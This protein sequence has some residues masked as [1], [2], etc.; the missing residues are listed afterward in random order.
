MRGW[1]SSQEGARS[2]PVVSRSGAAPGRSRS[3]TN[4][5]DVSR[6][7]TNTA[8]RP[9]P[10]TVSERG[11]GVWAITSSRQWGG[12]GTSLRSGTGIPARSSLPIQMRSS[13]S[14]SGTRRSLLDPGERLRHQ[15]ADR[16]QVVAA[17]LDE[18]GWE[19]HI[20]PGIRP[21][22][23]WPSAV[24]F[25][26]LSGSPAAA[27][28]PRATTRACCSDGQPAGS[29]MASS[30][31]SGGAFAGLPPTRAG[32]RRAVAGRAAGVRRDGWRER[33]ADTRVLAVVLCVTW[34]LMFVVQRLALEVS[35]P[36][37][38][39]AGRASIGAVALLPF[40]GQLRHLGRRG[41]AIACVLGLTNQFGFLGLQVA[42][43]RTVEAGPAAA[44]IYL[45]PVLVVLASGPLLG[46]RLTARRLAGALLGFAGVAVVGLHQSAS[47][48]A[49][50]V[51]LLLA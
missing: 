13:G 21:T 33:L 47:A 36:A 25:S 32:R 49:A 2:R 10:L 37:W 7:S 38:V 18:D 16:G 40:A 9:S 12:G 31:A 6:S 19:V 51:L 46:E 11:L 4:R 50:G 20:A 14:G 24:T 44:I 29:P 48:S 35:G 5:S 8:V 34:G 42:G 23:R 28:T 22:S 17:L 27:S 3:R 43:L 45:Q 30:R 39:A 1:V 41:V 15:G 26:R